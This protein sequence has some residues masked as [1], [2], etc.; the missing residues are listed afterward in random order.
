MITREYN[1]QYTSIYYRL[2]P[3]FVSKTEYTTHAAPKFGGIWVKDQDLD[4]AWLVMDLP[5]MGER[6][7]NGHCA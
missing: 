7:I 4:I 3:S 1:I 6:R 2:I 5:E